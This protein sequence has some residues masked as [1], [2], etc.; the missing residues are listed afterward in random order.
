MKI[1]LAKLSRQLTAPGRN[2]SSSAMVLKTTPMLWQLLQG[3]SCALLP[4]AASV[5]PTHKH[6]PSHS[7]LPG[8]RGSHG[9]WE[10]PPHSTG[11][12]AVLLLGSSQ[13]TFQVN[14]CSI[15]LHHLVYQRFNL[16]AP[17]LQEGKKQSLPGEAI[18][19]PSSYH[20]AAK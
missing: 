10:M 9:D 3:L 13:S 17:L 15:L 18:T 16:L 2:G 19:F 5:Q 4:A 20:S 6:A 11:S 12:G 14:L 8:T 7:A 1:Q